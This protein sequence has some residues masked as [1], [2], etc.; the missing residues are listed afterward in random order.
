MPKRPRNLKRAQSLAAVSARWGEKNG[1]HSTEVL[2]D[3]DF[4][5]EIS[6][7]V[8][9]NA[10]KA[11]NNDNDFLEN[12]DLPTICDLF[13]FCKNEYGSRKLTT[14][15]YMILRYLGHH[16]RTIDDIFRQIVANQ[17]QTAHRWAETFISDDFEAFIDDG[18]GGK[19]TDSFYDTFPEL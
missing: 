3:E 19:T 13:G 8:L 4:A 2:S 10:G 14:L 11:F 18:C 16:W 5:D 17:C 15:L 12:L 7:N 6:A 1:A 9:K